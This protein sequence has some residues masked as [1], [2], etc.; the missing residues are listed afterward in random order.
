MKK[1]IRL[2]LGVLILAVTIAA[3]IRYA[4]THPALIDKLR[5]IEPGLMVLL[6][7]LYILWFVALAVILR[8][9][10]KMYR[11]PMALQENFLLNAYST[12]ANFFGP[13]QSGPAVRGVYLKKRHN[14]SVK[15]YI[16]AT[17]IYYGFYAI[18]SA[19]MLF[20]GSRPWWQTVLLMLVAGTASLLVIRLYAKRS[21]MK[22]EGI[23]P[24]YLMLIFLATAAQLFI[25]FVIFAIELHSVEA[26]ASFGQAITYTGAANFALFVSLTPGAI[27]IREAFLVFSQQLHHISNTLVVAANVIDRAVYLVFLGILFICALAMHAKDKLRFKQVTAEPPEEQQES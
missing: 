18:I 23:S 14:L 21:H 12:L 24:K 10:L 20:V 7:A 16:F 26:H 13:G 17:L 9:T 2:G 27:G 5:D 11:T 1:K 3:F 22:D 15:K 8:L 4:T 19:F 25:Q 6:V